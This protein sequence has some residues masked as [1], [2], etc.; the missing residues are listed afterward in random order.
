[1]AYREEWVGFWVLRWLFEGELVMKPWGQ[2]FKQIWS[3]KSHGVWQGVYHFLWRIGSLCFLVLHCV[4]AFLC[5]L[6]RSSVHALL[7]HPQW[8]NIPE[9]VHGINSMNFSMSSIFSCTFDWWKPFLPIDFVGTSHSDLAET[10]IWVMVVAIFVTGPRDAGHGHGGGQ[11]IWL[12]KCETWPSVT[13]ELLLVCFS[14]I[15]TAGLR[16]G[17]W[18][19]ESIHIHSIQTIAALQPIV[20]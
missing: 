7:P 10:C 1:M 4:V 6:P 5:R 3:C 14:T 9:L 19:Q 17:Y 15:W 18:T 8:T 20:M 16:H 12:S 2:R 13:G 11:E